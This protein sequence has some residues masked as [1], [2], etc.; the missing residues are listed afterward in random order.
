MQHERPPSVVLHQTVRRNCTELIEFPAALPPPSPPTAAAAD[1]LHGALRVC[2]A[3]QLIQLRC[4]ECN[5]RGLVKAAKGKYLKKCPEVSRAT[6]SACYCDRRCSRHPPAM[7][8][9]LYGLQVAV[10]SVLPC[11]SRLGS[12]RGSWSTAGV[13][14]DHARSVHH[15]LAAVPHVAV[16]RLL[17]VGVVE[18]LLDIDCGAG[19]RRWV[20]QCAGWDVVAAEAMLCCHAAKSASPK[21]R[22]TMTL[23]RKTAKALATPRLLLKLV[24]SVHS[25]H[26]TFFTV[27]T[28]VG[29]VRFGVIALLDMAAQRDRSAQRCLL[30][31]SCQSFTTERYEANEPQWTI[32][33][34][35]L[36]CVPCACGK[37]GADI[38]VITRWPNVGASA[39]PPP[40]QARSSSPAARPVCSTRCRRHRASS[41]SR[42]TVDPA[43]RPARWHSRLLLRRLSRQLRAAVARQQQQQSRPRRRPPAAAAS[44]RGA[45]HS[46]EV[47]ILEPAR[48]APDNVVAAWH[49][50]WLSRLQSVS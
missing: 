47:R 13:P 7:V 29:M 6:A 3:A 12:W 17:P 8:S 24:S 45:K 43:T 9:T 15:A 11:P 44:P 18:A 4:E 39:Q 25:F 22:M 40:S 10:P 2:R 23:P 42:R 48:R 26:A 28:H 34:D 21:L 16:R 30:I 37:G 1:S 33:D 41:A 50:R 46:S 36:Q 32:F 35:K 20:V 38:T 31:S 27:S 14:L 5:G 49:P 19:Q